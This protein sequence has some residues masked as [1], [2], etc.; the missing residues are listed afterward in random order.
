MNRIEQIQTFLKDSP[1]DPFLNY[2]LAQEYYKLGDTQQALNLYCQLVEQTPTYVATYYHLGKLYIELG[3]RELAMQ[4][5]ESG[6]AMA[7]QQN[8]RHNLAELQSARLEL[9]Y[10]ED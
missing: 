9:L 6:I 1:Q 5:F 4:T 3:Q 2:A 7:T 10:D 8:E